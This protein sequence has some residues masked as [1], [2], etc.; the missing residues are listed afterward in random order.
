VHEVGHWLGL[1]H[2]FQGGCD[3]KG[4]R[5]RDTAA[6]AVPNSGY[7]VEPIN[8]CPGAGPDPIEN[9][10][11]YTNKACMNEFSDGQSSRMQKML[12]RF[13]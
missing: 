9:F 5:V 1:F 2:T 11:N 3:G 7:P 8:T 6:Q 13:R 10:M 12:S 4:D